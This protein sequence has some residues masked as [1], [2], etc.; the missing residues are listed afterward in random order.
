MILE[1]KKI[2][3]VSIYD[4]S[5]KKL[6]NYQ[7]V[8][9]YHI[10]NTWVSFDVT[11]PVGDVL[12][13]KKNIFSI[14]I[15]ITAFYPELKDNLKLSLM[16]EEEN[17]EHDYPILLLSYS[18]VSIEGHDL[19]AEITSNKQRVKRNIEDDYEEETNKIWDDE[20]SGKKT[21]IKKFKKLRNTCKK[22]TLYVDFAEISYDSWIVQPKGYEVSII[23]NFN[24]T[25]LCMIFKIVYG[26][27]ILFNGADFFGNNPNNPFVVIHYTTSSV[28]YLYLGFT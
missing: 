12:K 7:E 18:S 8:P 1:T 6:L 11:G 24:Y 14:V 21:M 15:T 5:L 19:L 20:F 3:K 23:N 22:K 27:P 25:K 10:N 9:I 13:N 2:L 4:E 28:Y 17:F 26:W 16:P